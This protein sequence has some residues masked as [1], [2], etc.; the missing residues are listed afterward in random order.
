MNA[1]I[2]LLAAKS[3][4]TKKTFDS[5]R[6]KMQ[7]CFSGVS[8][9]KRKRSLSFGDLNRVEKPSYGLWRHKTELSQI[10]TW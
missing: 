6:L 2:I 1:S 3:C 7:V 9:V 10:V 8:F 4:F 5:Q